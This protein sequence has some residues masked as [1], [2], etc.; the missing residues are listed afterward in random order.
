MIVILVISVKLIL[1]YPDNMKEKM[2]NILCSWKK[3]N[4]DEF[5]RYMNENKPKTY[6][7]QEHIM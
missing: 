4:S 5:T 2:E 6:T 1:K 3:I 7:K